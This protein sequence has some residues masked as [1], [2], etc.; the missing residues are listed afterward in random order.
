MGAG[1]AAAFL[2]DGAEVFLV[3]CSFDDHLAVAGE[4]AAFTG[5]AGGH[6]AIK[7]IHAAGDV[8]EQIAGSAHAHQ[9]AGFVLRKNIVQKSCDAEHIFLGFS[10]RQASDGIAGEV[11]LHQFFRAFLPQ[12]FMGAA[13]HDAKESLFLVVL[14]GYLATFR[15]VQSELEGFLQ[16][17]AA[18]RQ[19]RTFVKA[20]DDI[21]ANGFLNLHN[22][23]RTKEMQAAVDMAAELHSLRRDLTQSRETHHLETTA[24]GEHGTVPTDEFVQASGGADQFVPG[25]HV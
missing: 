10:H 7:H 6:H 5:V 2:V 18:G 16:I 23:L 20:H 22:L 4:D 14:K 21:G 25:A 15:P 9:V 13:L 17:L 3:T 1:V 12:V 19:G 8:I 24:I 11:H